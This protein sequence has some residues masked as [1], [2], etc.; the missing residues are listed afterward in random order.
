MGKAEP[1]KRLE[2]TDSPKHRKMYE[3]TLILG[4]KN[5]ANYDKL[6]PYLGRY[7]H[8]ASDEREEPGDDDSEPYIIMGLPEADANRL[9]DDYEKNGKTPLRYL[10]SIDEYTFS[11]RP[12]F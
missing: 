7:G 1:P 10:K 5:N 2:D 11:S 8:I 4:V 3:V 6:L 9:M 12:A